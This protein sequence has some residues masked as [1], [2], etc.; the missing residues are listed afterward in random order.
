M[1]HRSLF[2]IIILLCISVTSGYSYKDSTHK[3][4]KHHYWINLGA[5]P[6]P[7]QGFHY[8]FGGTYLFKNRHV[9]QF[10]YLTVR[11][12][13]KEFT[14]HK[15]QSFILAYGFN[16]SI[17]KIHSFIFTTGISRGKGIY[18][19]KDT[20]SSQ[21]NWGHILSKF[22]WEDNSY[23]R[24]TYNYYGVYLS[25]QYLIRTRYYGFGVNLYCNIHRYTDY[26][27][28]FSHNFGYLNKKLK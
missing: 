4:G 12:E 1:N 26:G 20:S 22:K 13:P 8:D 14:M 27:L 24:S 18:Y 7:V 23:L 21:A 2:I 5:G 25:A 11:Y 6:G 15:M 16:K 9:M 3:F 19:G 28:T 10:N 17:K